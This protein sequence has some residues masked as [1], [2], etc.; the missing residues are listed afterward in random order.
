[1]NNY[2]LD[3]KFMEHRKAEFLDTARREALVRELK[4][5]GKHRTKTGSRTSRNKVKFNWFF[6]PKNRSATG[7]N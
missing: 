1:M 4:Q 6:G 5:T 3:E 2:Y 7:T